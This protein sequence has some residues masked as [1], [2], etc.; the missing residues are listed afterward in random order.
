MP[1]LPLRFRS[2]DCRPP[3]NYIRILG[4]D[5]VA[6]LQPHHFLSFIPRRT[7]CISA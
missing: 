3:E 5:I 2:S 1:S 7:P 6:F 4:I